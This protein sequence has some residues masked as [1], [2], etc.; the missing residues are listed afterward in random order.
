MLEY[1]SHDPKNAFAV[2]PALRIDF[3]A[4]ALTLFLALRNFLSDVTNAPDYPVIARTFTSLCK[5]L[6]F[7]PWSREISGVHDFLFSRFRQVSEQNR[8][9]R[10]NPARE[11]PQF[12]QVPG[13]WALTPSRQT[14]LHHAPLSPIRV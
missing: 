3:G 7:R 13:A 14:R 11:A 12:Q 6:F 8:V 2:Y 5:S 4:S 1:I 9:P 10:R